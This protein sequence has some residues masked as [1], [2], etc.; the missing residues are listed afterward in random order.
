MDRLRNLGRFL[1]NPEEDG[2]IDFALSPLEDL[3]GMARS[4]NCTIAF[5][6]L[7]AKKAILA[8]IEP[9][10]YEVVSKVLVVSGETSFVGKVVRVGGATDMRCGLRVAFQNRMLICRVADKEIAQTIGKRLYEDIVVHGAVVWI[11]KSWKIVSF[12]IQSVAHLPEVPISKA[13]E[14]LWEAGG[15]NWDDVADPSA[16]LEKVTGER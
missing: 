4:S 15:K 10:S 16:Y 9:G 13:F 3:S 14:D 2:E 12:T 6:E 11:K 7:T 5:R 1:A 8:R